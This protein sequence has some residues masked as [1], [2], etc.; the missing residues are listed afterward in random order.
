MLVAASAAFAHEYWIEPQRSEL[1]PGEELRANLKNGQNFSGSTFSYIDS[2]FERFELLTP[3]RTLAVEGRNGDQ[4]AL[5]MPVEE[6]GLHVAIYRS[7]FD[8]LT[9][10]LWETFEAYAEYEGLD[11]AIERHRARGLPEIGFREKYARCAK[12]LVQVGKVDPD[13]PG[14]RLT[15]LEFELVAG[16][17]P[18]REGIS[19]MPLTLYLDGKPVANRQINVFRRDGETQ[20]TRVRTGPD[21]SVT[22]P[23]MP[24]SDYLLNAV[25]LFEGDDDPQTPEPEWLSYW[26]S[27]VFS[28][29]GAR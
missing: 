3:S 10:A 20:L 5:S 2:R 29:P 6:D 12:T 27:M 28:V 1:A 13:G 4:P 21:G 19:E 16:D 14:D 8:T 7:T 17:N 26:A 18:Y 15:G 11:G 23:L 22:I 25:H 9:Y 24:G